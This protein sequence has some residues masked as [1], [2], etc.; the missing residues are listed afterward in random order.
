MKNLNGLRKLLIIILSVFLIIVS[1]GVII[2]PSE[3]GASFVA[4]LG[5][6]L[7]VLVMAPFVLPNLENEDDTTNNTISNSIHVLQ[8]ETSNNLV[9]GPDERKVYF[10]DSNGQVSGSRIAKIGEKVIVETQVI[11]NAQIKVFANGT[12]I[13]CSFSDATH[14]EYA[15]IM[16]NGDVAVSIVA[17]HL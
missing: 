14:C 11:K 5:L 2:E 13:P 4:W 15:F 3:Q 17:T 7:Y 9:C 16:P 6:I 1:I 12:E 8:T 10:L